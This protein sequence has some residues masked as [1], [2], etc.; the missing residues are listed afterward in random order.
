[1][2]ELLRRLQDINRKAVKL[3]K[4][5]QKLQAEKDRL[6]K[7]LKEARAELDSKNGELNGMG[8][9]YEALKLAKS[10]GNPEDRDSV[11]AK[12][13]LYLKEI[14]ICLKTLGD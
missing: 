4:A 7:E 13:D 10:I 14:D 3:E 1:M 2:D 12:I 5:M 8:E 11:M 6:G 9:R